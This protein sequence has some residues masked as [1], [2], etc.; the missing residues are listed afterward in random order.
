MIGA[1]LTGFVLQE[2]CPALVQSFLNLTPFNESCELFLR[3]LRS[4]HV[5]MFHSHPRH[6]RPHPTEP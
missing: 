1:G 6:T 3:V 2:M 4:V 5:V